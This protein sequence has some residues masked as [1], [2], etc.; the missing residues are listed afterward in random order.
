V[1][2][3]HSLT[4]R[5]RLLC[6]RFAVCPSAT[7]VSNLEPLPV[8][9]HGVRASEWPRQPIG[10]AGAGDGGG[11]DRRGRPTQPVDVHRLDAGRDGDV[12]GV[13]VV[14]VGGAAFERK[15]ARGRE[16]GGGGGGGAG[17]GGEEGEPEAGR[18]RHCRRRPKRAGVLWFPTTCSAVHTRREDA[19]QRRA[20]FSAVVSAFSCVAAKNPHPGAGILTG[21]PFAIR[22]KVR[23]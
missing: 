13:G 1:L 17:S 4:V 18:G 21:F 3:G 2:T 14:T 9:L 16:R 22:R 5:V 10:I 7:L 8:R 6:C 19:E 11:G 15:A 23:L 20:D 12:I